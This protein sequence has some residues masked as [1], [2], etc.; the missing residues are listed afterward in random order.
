MTAKELGIQ[1]LLISWITLR[2]FDHTKRMDVTKIP[3]RA[4]ELKCKGRRPMG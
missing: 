1:N 2:Q 3:R 4:I